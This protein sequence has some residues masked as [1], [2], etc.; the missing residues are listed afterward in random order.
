[1]TARDRLRTRMD[2]ARWR[3]YTRVPG[4]PSIFLRWQPGRA[5]A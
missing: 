5:G 2:E 3:A 4:S 1:M